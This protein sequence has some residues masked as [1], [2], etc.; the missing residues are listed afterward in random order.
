LGKNIFTCADVAA[1]RDADAKSNA[2]AHISDV[3]KRGQ[4][5]IIVTKSPYFIGLFAMSAKSIC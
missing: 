4:R 1:M 3:V 5:N 2:R